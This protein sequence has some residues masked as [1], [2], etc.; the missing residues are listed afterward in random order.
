MKDL[1]EFQ[2]PDHGN[3][4]DFWCYRDESF[5]GW[6]GVFAHS[7]GGPNLCGTVAERVI[8]SYRAWIR[9]LK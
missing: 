9:D 1:V 8:K 2:A 7:K 3:P 6:V 5:V 4:A